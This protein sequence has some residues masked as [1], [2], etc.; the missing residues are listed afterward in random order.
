MAVFMQSYIVKCIS[1]SLFV[2]SLTNPVANPGMSVFRL[3]VQK[4]ILLGAMAF[5]G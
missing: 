3:L 4:K 1:A 5:N 2:L